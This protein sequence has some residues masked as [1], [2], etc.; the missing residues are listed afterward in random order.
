M[1]RFD[2][3]C[4][5]A[6]TFHTGLTAFTCNYKNYSLGSLAQHLFFL[7]NKLKHGLISPLNMYPLFLG[8]SD[9]SLGSDNTAFLHR[10][11]GWLWLC[12]DL[13]FCLDAVPSMP[14]L[15]P[16]HWAYRSSGYSRTLV[17]PVFC[18]VRSVRKAEASHSQSLLLRQKQNS[19]S[20][21]HTVWWWLNYDFENCSWDLYS[22][23][24]SMIKS[25][26]KKQTS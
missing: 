13:D 25:L 20:I 4:I 26:W 9:M 1:I 23:A 21:S 6:I 8:P 12:L 24:A 18:C 3:M 2:I 10:I 22:H 14:F 11:Y 17:L 16:G 19:R 5:C 15:N 7:K